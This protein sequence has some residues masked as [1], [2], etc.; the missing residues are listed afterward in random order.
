MKGFQ[1]VMSGIYWAK[2][3]NYKAQVSPGESFLTNL[4]VKVIK[5]L[6][7]LIEDLQDAISLGLTCQCLLKISLNHIN[8]IF[9]VSAGRW[10]GGCITCISDFWGNRNMSGYM[11]T[12]KEEAILK[13]KGI[14]L[15]QY[16]NTSEGV[17]GQCPPQCDLS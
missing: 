5:M 13:D 2:S 9:A 14:S 3:I 12:P 15:Y 10:A 8:Q 17:Y 4:P 6:F 7:K 1:S 16:D 11:L